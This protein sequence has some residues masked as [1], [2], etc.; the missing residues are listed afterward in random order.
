M[1]FQK[2]ETT[3]FLRIFLAKKLDHLKASKKRLKTEG[4][5]E[6]IWKPYPYFK[7]I[8]QQFVNFENWII[9]FIKIYPSTM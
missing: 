4:S 9:S 5:P 2:L 1:A 6:D 3:I 8:F 7:P